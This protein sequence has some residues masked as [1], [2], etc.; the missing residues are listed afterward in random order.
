MS[1]TQA[2]FVEK[3]GNLFATHDSSIESGSNHNYDIAPVPVKV[4]EVSTENMP[5][6][7]LRDTPTNNDF[8]TSVVST[9]SQKS[10]NI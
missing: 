2:A 1:M 9:K 10:T 4:V 6:W 7:N 5:V 3:G 8:V